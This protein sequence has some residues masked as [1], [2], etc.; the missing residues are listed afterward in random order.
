M[1]IVRICDLYGTLWQ[2]IVTLVT[3]KPQETAVHV[4]TVMPL[5]TVVTGNI[6]GGTFLTVLTV[7]I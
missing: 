7:M 3:L 1:L 2:L 4:V 6:A 5:V